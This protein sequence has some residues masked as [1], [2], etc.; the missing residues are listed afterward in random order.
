V[1]TTARNASG[2]QVQ[3]TIDTHGCACAN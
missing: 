2:E 3:F 1:R